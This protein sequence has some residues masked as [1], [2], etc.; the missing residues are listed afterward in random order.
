M[1]NTMKTLMNGGEVEEHVSMGHGENINKSLGKE[2]ENKRD[3]LHTR[4]LNQ[5]SLS[6]T[7]NSTT[8]EW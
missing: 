6:A 5:N 3:Y 7:E 2:M 8:N 4:H 1:S